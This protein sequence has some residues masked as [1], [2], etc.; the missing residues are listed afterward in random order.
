MNPHIRVEFRMEG[1]GHLVFV[2][3][4]D[5]PLFHNREHFHAVP[6]RC[7]IRRTDKRHRHCSNAR[8]RC[9]CVEAAQLAAVGIPPD[10]HRNRAELLFRLSLDLSF[11][12][13]GQK[14]RTGTG[15]ENRHTVFNL[16]FH[17]I[18]HAKLL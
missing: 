4:T 14:N 3:Y 12:L 8:N 18:E 6:H 9:F 2:F 5:D 13:F 17:G 16:A 7:D 11:D 10:A 1:E 15:R